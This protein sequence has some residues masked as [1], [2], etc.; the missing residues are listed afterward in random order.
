MRTRCW[1][2]WRFLQLMD[3]AEIEV[4]QQSV[5]TCLAFNALQA[6]R[7]TLPEYRQKALAM[8]ART[9]EAEAEARRAYVTEQGCRQHRQCPDGPVAVTAAEQA[10]D[11]ARERTAQHL[12]ATRLGQLHELTGDRVDAAASAAAPWA[13]RLAPLADRPVREEVR[14]VAAT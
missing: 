7:A 13:E 10:A 5:D 14:V 3:P 9:P 4:D 8:L 2:R 1:W 12:L 11:R 6:V